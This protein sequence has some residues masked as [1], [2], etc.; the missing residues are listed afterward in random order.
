VLRSDSKKHFKKAYKNYR[1]P[2]D[3]SGNQKSSFKRSYDMDRKV[4]KSYFLGISFVLDL[5]AGLAVY[6][7]IKGV[8]PSTV[9]W[10]AL[11]VIALGVIIDLFM[12]LGHLKRSHLEV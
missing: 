7:V 11:G 1:Y 6:S 12:M 9:L 10:F 2:S 3:I 8:L 5:L 4:L